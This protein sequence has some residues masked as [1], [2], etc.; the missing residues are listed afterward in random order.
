M[1]RQLRIY[2]FALIALTVVVFLIDS[3]RK[4]PLNWSPTYNLNDKIPLGLYVLDHEIDSLLEHSV[5]RYDKTP[6]E[7][8]DETENN[9]AETYLF[10]NARPLIDNQSL[11]QLLDK[12]KKGNTLFIS[13]EVFPHQLL[14]TLEVQEAYEFYRPQF[15]QK[16][17]IELQL[18]Q[19]DWHETYTLTPVF[20]QKRFSLIDTATTS[21]LGFS[22]Y[23]ETVRYISFVKINLGKGTVFLHNQPAAFSNH[24]LLAQSELSV[25]AARTLSYLPSNTPVVW[26]VQGQRQTEARKARTALSV[27]FQYPALRAAWLIFLYGL[28]LFIFFRAKRTQRVVPI[29]KPP[30]NTTVEF[31]QTIGNLYYQEG[32]TA[33]I[34][35][36]KIVY[37]LDKIRKRY[38]LDT[39]KLDD[40]FIQKLHLKSGKEIKLIENI[41]HFIQWFERN[42][43]AHQTD[44]IRLNEFLE[45]FWDG[46]Y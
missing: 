11:N 34:V 27:V 14:D 2:L 18:T 45:E 9:H 13:A 32:D 3:G 16:D 10:I 35:Q 36:K 15:F 29:I 38:Y 43:T 12:V 17:T 19:P 7:Y 4:K 40:T 33:N 1:N 24:S 30:A 25:Y 26:F 5:K 23:Q 8:L 46:E 21:V 31:T 44:L 39:Q 42:N 37:F 28:L 22:L 20:G 41:V 6:Y